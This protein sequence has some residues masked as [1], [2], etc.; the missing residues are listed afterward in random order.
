MMLFHFD[1]GL[2]TSLQM[3]QVISMPTQLTNE[4]PYLACLL[5]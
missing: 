3:Y 4:L 2:V 5:K 1:L